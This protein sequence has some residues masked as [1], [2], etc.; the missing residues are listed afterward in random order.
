MAGINNSQEILRRVTQNDPSLTKLRLVDNNIYGDDGQFHSNNSDDYSTLGSAIANN[1]HL[2]R[3]AVILSDDLPL[4]VADRDFFNGLKS[5]SS[6]N[7]LELYCNNRN[8]AGGVGQE[9][10]QAYQ[11]NNNHLTDLRITN[12]NLQSGGIVLSRIR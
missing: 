3:L 9:I 10:L 5:N 2:T 7:N 12:A 11:E 4:G 1:T 8:I 6:I